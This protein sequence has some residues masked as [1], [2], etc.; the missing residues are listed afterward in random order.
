[1]ALPTQ[2][3]QV[4]L[5]ATH[6]WSSRGPFL[7]FGEGFSICKS[8]WKMCISTVYPG[9][10]EGS[11][12]ERIWGRGLSRED[13]IGSCLV[14][15]SPWL[16]PEGSNAISPPGALVKDTLCRARFRGPHLK[17]VGGSLMGPCLFVQV[18]CLHKVTQVGITF[19]VRDQCVP[20]Q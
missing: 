2:R 15:P 3:H 1:M 8:T 20:S 12:R 6:S 18:M 11:Y 10:S 5:G 7:P 4:S 16:W 9:T 13:P 17:Q 14:T 19:F